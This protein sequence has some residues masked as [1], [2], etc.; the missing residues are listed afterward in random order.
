[1]A[2]VA[3]SGVAFAVILVAAGA[4]AREIDVATVS[5]AEFLASTQEVKASLVSW[6]RGYHAGKS[7]EI[8]YDSAAPYGARLGRYCRDHPAAK[9]I[10]ASEQI[11]GEFGRG[12]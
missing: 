10:D 4:A 6:L 12:I 9:L 7:G 2:R 8:A 1:M 11:L 3:G 5:C